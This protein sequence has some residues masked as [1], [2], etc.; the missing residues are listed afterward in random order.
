MF[1]NKKRNSSEDPSISRVSTLGN[2]KIKVGRFTYGHED[3][4]VREWGEGFNLEIGQFCSIAD[5]VT[6]F[7][8]GNHRTDY[9][10]TYPFGHVF[11][12]RLGNEKVKGHPQS[13]GD[14]SIGNDVWIGSGTTILSGVSIG[15]GAV[16]AARSLITK[17]VEP[18]QVV[19]G[20]PAKVIRERF[21][22]DVVRIL[23]E[24]AW[25]DLDLDEIKDLRAILGGK[26]NKQELQ[27]IVRKLKNR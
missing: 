14:V 23:E 4:H 25:W 1:P 18:Y 15:N 24:L 11:Q 2:S 6:V 16:L 26:P 22:P 8:G 20:N 10:S 21:S 13:N 9:I 7:L 27:R 3:I 5:G 19:G 17:N 12:N